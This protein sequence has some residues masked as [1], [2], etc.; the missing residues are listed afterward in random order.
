VTIEQNSFTY[1]VG[2]VYEVRLKLNNP[3]NN[4][5]KIEKGDQLTVGIARAE[6]VRSDGTLVPVK[7]SP[8]YVSF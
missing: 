7:A 1:P 4:L 8:L 3:S 2:K 6:F 5:L